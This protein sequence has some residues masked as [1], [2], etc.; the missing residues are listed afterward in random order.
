M[1]SLKAS[2]AAQEEKAHENWVAARQAERRLTEVQ[3]EMSVLRNRL[4]VAESKNT[5]LEQEKED[6]SGAV[7]M[8]QQNANKVEL[9][10][11]VKPK[12]VSFAGDPTEFEPQNGQGET[13]SA[14]NPPSESG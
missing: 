7:T 14:S 13:R 10:G 1:G 3:S 4:T 8:L 6:L 11:G 12:T 5:L 2:V 9:P